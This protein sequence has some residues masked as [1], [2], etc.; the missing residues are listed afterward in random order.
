MGE[1]QSL[2]R[3]TKRRCL[4]VSFRSL[5]GRLQVSHRKGLP[6]IIYCRLWRWP[7]LQSHH[8]LRAV[9]HCGF[10]FH[11]KKEEVCVNP[12]HYQ[13]VET[14]SEST[15][16]RWQSLNPSA[17]P[18]SVSASPVLPPVLVP[19]HADVPAEF[20]LLD[21][22]SPSIPENTSFPADVEP[23]SNYIPGRDKKKKI[24]LSHH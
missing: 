6:H 11:T 18:E 10:A 22:Y 17:C 3:T 23:H 9:D 12:Y 7:D 24:S 4:L 5:D 14:P 13:R 15:F 16:S 1:S 8:E 20:P 21:D 19:R 2:G